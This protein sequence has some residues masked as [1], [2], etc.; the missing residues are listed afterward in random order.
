MMYVKTRTPIR[1][2]GGKIIG[3]LEEDAQ[4]D[5]Q[6]RDFTGHILGFYRKKEDKTRD[7]YGRIVGNGNL[8]IM[9]LNR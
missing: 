5:Q 4:G 9:L 1:Q 6:I 2:F 3:F 7:F 8:L